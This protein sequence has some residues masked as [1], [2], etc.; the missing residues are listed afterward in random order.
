MFSMSMALRLSIHINMQ[1]IVFISEIPGY[2]LA[3][4]RLWEILQWRF[5]HY[6][7]R[8]LESFHM[9]S[10]FMYCIAFTMQFGDHSFYMYINRAS[11][12]HI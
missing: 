1:Q 3:Q 7:E 11:Y 6:S 2:K 4:R 9:Y 5:L 8:K 10:V 12:L